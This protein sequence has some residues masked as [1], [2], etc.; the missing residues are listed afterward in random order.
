M[1]LA[2]DANLATRH[3]TL[4]ALRGFAVMG[5]LAMNIIAF[6]MPEMAY[7]TPALD[8]P[9]SLGDIVSWAFSF[10]AADGKMRGLFSLLFGA[11]MLL[12]VERAQAKG[13]SPA[14]VHFR[15]MGWL[16]L[17]G[18]AHFLLI[19]WGDILFLYAV[20]GCV[21][22]LF[23]DVEARGL[24]KMALVIY[25]IGFLLMSGF[26]GMMFLLEFAAK[27]PDADPEMVKAY[28]EMLAGFGTAPK[29]IAVYRG[30]YVDIIQYRASEKWAQPVTMVLQ[31][32]FETLPFMMIGMALY[33][34]GFM[35]GRLEPALYRKWALIGIG[36]GGMA[37]ALFV[38]L[39]ISYDFGLILMMNISLAWTYPF[40]LLMIIGYAAALILLIRAFA[41]SG[42]MARV[43]AA[44]RAAFS[45]YLGTSIVMTTIF[46][47]YGLGHFNEVGR[48]QLWLFVIGAWIAMLLW[49]K[50]WLDRF[51]YGP[52]EWLWR[53]LA[54]WRLQPL[55][56]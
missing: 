8:G 33:K 54:R 22:Y 37:Y 40:R 24:I 17:I 2:N 34:N 12:I 44:G 16:A 45:N 27:L 4:D 36:I 23:R 32:I 9:A 28:N 15:R 14:S 26:M 53:S 1:V 47:G 21:A 11:S 29:E 20:V 48:A 30:G 31:N 39:A 52:F 50:P 18:L 38:V 55:K 46:Y 51:N 25:L 5:I 49:S 10:I 3:I 7:L 56:R 41:Q 35:I 19:W 42:W 43:A 13:E 6:A